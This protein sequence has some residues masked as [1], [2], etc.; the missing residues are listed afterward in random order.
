MS[1]LVT[2]VTNCFSVATVLLVSL[3]HSCHIVTIVIASVTPVTLLG[4]DQLSADAIK[5]EPY[6]PPPPRNV[7]SIVP[8]DSVSS[9]SVNSL[10]VVTETEATPTEGSPD[11]STE[12]DIMQK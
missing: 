6:A 5:F 9:P 10:P 1:T 2:L 12:I 8:T 7:G 11:A 4:Q 3:T